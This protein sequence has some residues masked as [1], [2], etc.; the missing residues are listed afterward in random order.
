MTTHSHVRWSISRPNVVHETLDGEV[1]AINLDTGSYYSLKHV[2]AEVWAMI[3][4]GGVTT[5][6][7]VRAVTRRYGSVGVEPA[8]VSLLGEL[9]QEGLVADEEATERGVSLLLEDDDVGTEG[10]LFE[11]PVLHKYTDMQDLILRDPIHEVDDTGW[12]NR[13]PEPAKP[14]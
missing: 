7:V 13:E 2:G 11:A 14:E 5:D 12:P 9:R 8:I 4:E 3:E 10:H 1:V 6:E